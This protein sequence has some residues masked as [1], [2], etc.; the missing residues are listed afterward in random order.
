MQLFGKIPDR[1][2]TIL[3]SPKKELYVQALFVL[4]QAFRTEL[5]IRRE[6]LTAMII[7][8]LEDDILNADFSEEA[9]AAGDDSLLN[10]Q[11]FNGGQSLSA[12]AHLLVRRLKETG[13]IEM[14]Y[15]KGTFDENVTIPDYAIEIMNLLYDLSQERVREYN[16]YVYATYASLANASQNQDYLYQALQTAWQNTVHLVDELKSLF[17]NIRAYYRRIPGEEDVNAL[18]SEHFDEYKEKIFDAVYYPLKTID[19]VPRFKHAIISTMNEWMS[20]EDIQE[21]IVR[22]GVTRRVFED[23]ESGRNEMLSMINYIAD[24]YDGIEDMINEIDRKHV[25]YT[26]ASV[27]HIRYL[28]NADRGLKGK[29]IELLKHTSDEAVVD[30]MSEHIDVYRH[31]YYDDKSL[32]AEVKRTKR[33]V[34]TPLAVQE[35]DVPSGMVH[36]FLAGVRSQF[37]NS[38]IDS[39]V[40]Q[41]FGDNDTVSTYT[42]SMKNS[43]DFILFLL[44]T[45]RGRERNAPYQVKF[46]DEYIDR[47]GYHLPQVTFYRKGKSGSEQ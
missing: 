18:L 27:E 22:Q 31:Q 28:M 42:V 5:V 15:E 35:A 3:T 36:S 45:V 20:D 19:S 11:S 25:D 30:A 1:F 37:P 7:D 32:Y 12:K 29:L 40:E 17:N 26:S 46:G 33:N 4:R 47:D 21:M 41:C 6:E 24:T 13:W 8:S 14:E 16:S 43:D 2:F 39:Y 44:G 38:R 23:E 9:E 10:S 34:G